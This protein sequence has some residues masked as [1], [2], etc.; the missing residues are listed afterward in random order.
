MSDLSIRARRY[1]RI[2][3]SMR[4]AE[5]IH[6]IV[7][8]FFVS[9]AWVRALPRTRRA[10]VTAIGLAGLGVTL[11]ACM[12]PRFLPPR[13]STIVRDWLPA[14]CVLLVYW[15]AGE[16]FVKVDQRL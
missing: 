14:A 13:P 6:L 1:A 16:F 7:F 11:A 15:Q 8:S 10:K 5:R 2:E 4:A 3:S 12:L 9:L